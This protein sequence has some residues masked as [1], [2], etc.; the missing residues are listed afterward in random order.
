MEIG[1]K[2]RTKSAFILIFKIQRREKG[3]KIKKL[4]PTENQIMIIM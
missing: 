1:P 3:K 2:C 4:L